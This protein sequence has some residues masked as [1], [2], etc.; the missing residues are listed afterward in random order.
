[1][2]EVIL[3]AYDT[4]FTTKS[5]PMDEVAGKLAVPAFIDREDLMSLVAPKQ[6]LIVGIVQIFLM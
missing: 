5:W 4:S 6:E 2:Q 3:M 1:M